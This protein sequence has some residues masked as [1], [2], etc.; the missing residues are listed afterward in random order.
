MSHVQDVSLHA[1]Q[2]DAWVI[3]RVEP[4][5]LSL[6]E[7]PVEVEDNIPRPISPCPPVYGGLPV[8]FWRIVH[9]VETDFW[10]HECRT[11]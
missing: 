5:P 6:K 2:H 7:E 4:L 9:A 3:Q 10:T 11:A 8:R 1:T